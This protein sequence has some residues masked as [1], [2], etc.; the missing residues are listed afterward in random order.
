MR[1]VCNILGSGPAGDFEAWLKADAQKY[2]RS[3][4]HSGGRQFS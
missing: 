1:H 4:D 2:C 3:P